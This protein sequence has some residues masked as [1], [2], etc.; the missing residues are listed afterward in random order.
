MS[1]NCG[2]T[3][4]TF[5]R[6]RQVVRAGTTAEAL[7]V[8]RLQVGLAGAMDLLDASRREADRSTHLD[9]LAALEQVAALHTDPRT[10]EPWLREVLDLQGDPEGVTLSTVHRVKGREW[11]FVIVVGAKE[12]SFPHRL[13]EDLEEERRVFHVAVTRGASGVV[14]IADRDDPSRFCAELFSAEP[15]LRPGRTTRQPREGDRK[16]AV[17]RL[18]PIHA[19]AVGAT[20]TL[21][22]GI[23]GVVREIAEDGLLVEGRGAR[24]RLHLGWDDE[25]T[26]E[27]RL[28]RLRRPGQPSLDEVTTALR[29]WRSETARRDKVPAYVVFN[30]AHLEGIAAAQPS[31]LDELARCRGVGPAKLEKYGD[32]LLSILERLSSGA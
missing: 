20:V 3:W 24:G 1:T 32:D 25:V 10:F 13:A 6:S 11:P 30:D 28:V 4:W 5:A 19:I 29:A 23:E 17:P 31:T 22:G 9:D 15:V 14:V 2:P 21:H 8:I 7:R 12:G 16:R 18:L 26:V 27:G